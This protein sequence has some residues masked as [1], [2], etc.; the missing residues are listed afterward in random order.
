MKFTDGLWIVKEGYKLETPKEIHDIGHSETGIT[1]FA[2]YQEQN[3]K[4]D[5][6]GCGMLTI[7]ITSPAANMLSIKITNHKGRRLSKVFFELNKNI[8]KPISSETETEYVYASSLLEARINKSGAWGISFYFSGNYLTSTDIGGMAH[9]VAPDGK[10]YIREQLNLSEGECIYGLGEQPGSI[11]RNGGSY[12]TW[13][14]DAGVDFGKSAVNVPFFL[15]SRGYGVLVNEAGRVEYEIANSCTTD[16]SDSGPV[17]RTQ[18]SV[19]GEVMEYIFIGGASP[20]HAL[21]LYSELVGHA[22]LP[23]AWAFGPWVSTSLLAEYDE[24]TVLDTVEKFR[25]TG[26]PLSVLHFSSTW[27][28]D[29]EWTNFLWDSERFPNPAQMI[30]KIHEKG[31]RVCLWIS[32]YISQK[33]PLFQEAFDGNY[34]INT[35]DGNVWQ[36]DYRQAGAGLLDFSNLVVRAWYQKFLD[37]LIRMGVD[38]FQLDFGADAPVR[39]PFFGHEA[40][41]HDITYKNNLDPKS[42]HNHYAYLYAE[43]VFE[44]LERR[45]GQN[46]VCLLTH[47]GSV[48]SQRFPFVSLDNTVSSFEGMQN[49]LRSGLSLSMSGFPYW[50]QNVGGMDDTCTPELFIRWQQQA[51][52]APHANAV[53]VSVPKEPWNF[54]DEANNEVVLFTKLKLGL[55]PY[56]FSSA[57][58]S[59][60]MGTP[61][62]RP[63]VL[64]FPRDGNTHQLDQQYMLGSNLL[65]APVTQPGG[66]VRYYVPAGVWTNLMTRERVEGPIWKNEQHN[67]G[68]MPILARP[69]TILAASQ[70]DSS[71]IYN[72]LENLTITLFEIPEDKEISTD[73]YSA[74]LKNMGL[75]RVLKKNQ[76]LT[77]ETQGIYGQTRLL[78]ANVFR[79]G[80]TS[81]GMPELNEWGT[82]IVYESESIEITLL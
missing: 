77:I 13:N 37:D 66:I 55:M 35:G 39:E 36:T 72:F 38:T 65:I 43:A 64:E 12:A 56:I 2:P 16:T 29:F 46:N 60:T 78:L 67:A 8:V 20:K 45:Y 11:V 73:L 23:P 22:S 33:S 4:A 79:I 26:T 74:D 25:S 76:K 18:F 57:V 69:G 54:G 24:E 41:E 5:S 3:T 28:K 21:S 58:E 61:M 10:S 68:S 47:S 1:L 62:T 50:S 42:M 7:R 9:I 63:M 80:E 30:R 51:L 81:V 49:A 53:G 19:E 14:E 31:V 48:G 75:I 82:M 40:M 34:F 32:P 6:I 59:S 15:S 71:S 52:F 70:N 17:A 44:V 27:M